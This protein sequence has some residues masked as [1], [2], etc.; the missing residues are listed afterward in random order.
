MGWES[1]TGH[2]A[3]TWVNPH[4]T[5]DGALGTA[6]ASEYPLTTGNYSSFLEL[7][8]ASLISNK[9]RV[10][11]MNTAY[12]TLTSI[13]LDVYYSGGWH[14]VYEGAANVDEWVEKTFSQNDVTKMRIRGKGTCTGA[15][16]R[17]PVKEVE[18]WE[19]EVAVFQPWAI[20]M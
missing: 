11:L 9:L 18:F 4:Y 20:I 5:Y 1:P 3:P 7:T 10:Y 16:P 14:D 17:F 6:G 13:D 15:Y 2:V 12:F 8:H 19:V